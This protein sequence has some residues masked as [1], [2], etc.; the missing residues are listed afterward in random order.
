VACVLNQSLFFVFEQIVIFGYFRAGTVLCGHVTSY[1]QIV[2]VKGICDG[3]ALVS[4]CL[5][6]DVQTTL[7]IVVIGAARIGVAI[8]KIGVMNAAIRS[9]VIDVR[10]TFFHDSSVDVV[11]EC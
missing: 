5:G 11:S 10:V 4:R 1:N 3:C 6:P 2:A 8:T 9:A 7:G